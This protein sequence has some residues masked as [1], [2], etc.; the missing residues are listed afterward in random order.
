MVG[1]PI[2]PP[3]EVSWEKGVWSIVLFATYPLDTFSKHC[4]LSSPPK[5][6]DLFFFYTFG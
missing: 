4:L 5:E 6:K 1:F 2:S 3:F